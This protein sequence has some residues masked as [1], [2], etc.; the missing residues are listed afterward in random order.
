MHVEYD[1]VLGAHTESDV[2]LVAYRCDATEPDAHALALTGFALP[3]SAQLSQT[4]LHVQH[5]AVLCV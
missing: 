5:H 4:C 2:L 1:A 3:P